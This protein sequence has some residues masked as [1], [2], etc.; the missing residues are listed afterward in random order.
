MNHFI[1]NIKKRRAEILSKSIKNK[2]FI[3][4][5]ICSLALLILGNYLMSYRIIIK[6]SKRIQSNTKYYEEYMIDNIKTFIHD[7]LFYLNNL[8]ASGKYQN[9]AEYIGFYKGKFIWFGST[10]NLISDNGF[11]LDKIYRIYPMKKSLIFSYKKNPTMNFKQKLKFELIVYNGKA[12]VFKVVLSKKFK[13]LDNNHK[14]SVEVN[15]ILEY[16]KNNRL[17]L[18][19]DNVYLKEVHAKIEK[20]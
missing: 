10:K 6:K 3:L 13:N 1:K 5:S 15:I 17:V 9:L 8:V 2:G 11:H 4:I 16:A 7:Q 12:N 20:K 14:I 18:N 19:P